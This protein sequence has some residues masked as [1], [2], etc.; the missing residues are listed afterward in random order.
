MVSI[1][2]NFSNKTFYTLITIL[3]L[4]AVAGIA[5]AYNSGNPEVMGHTV[6]EIDGLEQFII[7]TVYGEPDEL[8]CDSTPFVDTVSGSGLS[9][10]TTDEDDD[11][12]G[13]LETDLPQSF[14]DKGCVTGTG[15][16]CIIKQEIFY[17]NT[18]TP[19][20]VK[21]FGYIEDPTSHSWS[22]D[23]YDG[24]NGDCC[25]L[26]TKERITPIYKYLYLYDDYG[27]GL[28]SIDTF[29]YRDSNTR[30]GMKLYIC[31]S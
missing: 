9:Y 26:S 13:F 12:N 17:E 18:D 27:E 24:I 15:T 3:T 8:I 25:T 20:I 6:D 16:G 28:D 23:D 30:Y 29:T 4:V 19:H 11:V 1:N 5:F 14:W 21:L 10:R 7:N 22:S 2:L 31:S